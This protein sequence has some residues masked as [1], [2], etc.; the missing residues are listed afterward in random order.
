[1]DVKIIVPTGSDISQI[2]AEYPD[3]YQDDTCVDGSDIYF[4]GE[5]SDAEGNDRDSEGEW[6]TYDEA[7]ECCGFVEGSMPESETLIEGSGEWAMS[8]TRKTDLYLAAF[9]RGKE[10]CQHDWFMLCDASTLHTP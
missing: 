3:I 4:V 7:R 10:G 8:E 2:E 6:M 5:I 9:G 1:M